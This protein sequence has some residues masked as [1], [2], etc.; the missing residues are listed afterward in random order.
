MMSTTVIDKSNASLINQYTV[1]ELFGIVYDQLNDLVHYLA[2]RYSQ[3]TQEVLMEKDEIVGELYMEMWKGCLHYKDH[4]M[5]IEQLLAVLKV[6]LSNRV[7]ELKYRYFTTHRKI[8]QL[9]VTIEIFVDQEHEKTRGA[10]S[11]DAMDNFDP[12]QSL[13]PS[14]LQ[15]PAVLFDSSENVK[16]VR[17][18]LDNISKEV[19]DAC[20]YGHEQLALHVW[21]SAVRANAVYK[22]DRDVKIKPYH[23][24]SALCMPEDSVKLAIQNIS[25]A[26]EEV[27]H[28]V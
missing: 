4:D 27:Y 16:L 20:I 3:T 26:V 8:G 5:N 9:N 2:I 28:G 13:A 19:F 23:I 10:M 25:N 17:S 1:E 24:A 11:I 22:T 15:D 7:S 12:A 18:M 21:L 6:M 14:G